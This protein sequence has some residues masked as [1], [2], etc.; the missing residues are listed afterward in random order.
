MKRRSQTMVLTAL[1]GLALAALTTLDTARSH[2]RA[3]SNSASSDF[4]AVAPRLDEQTIALVRIDVAR[5]QPA[6]FGEFLSRLADAAGMPAEQLKQALGDVERFQQEWK[7]AG[8][9]ELYIALALT[10]APQSPAMALG[11]VRQGG[12]RASRPR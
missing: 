12:E 4:S 6:A 7:A 3:Q 10:D 8:G 9:S 11:V 5:V 2:V 1:V